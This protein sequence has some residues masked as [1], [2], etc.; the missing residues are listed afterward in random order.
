MT[1]KRPTLLDRKPT[2]Y[3]EDEALLKIAE[4]MDSEDGWTYLAESVEGDSTRFHINA[5]D[6]DGEL[7]GS[8]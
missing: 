5:Y 7:A 8:F 1:I 2:V 3:T 6:E 4:L